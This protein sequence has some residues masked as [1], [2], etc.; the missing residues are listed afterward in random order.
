M[1]TIYK[2]GMGGFLFLVS[3]FLPKNAIY[4]IVLI[5]AYSLL[6]YP[7]WIDVI[8]NIPKFKILDEKFLM[9]IATLG[10]FIIK[11]YPEAVAVI[12]FYQ[13]G[14]YLSDFA[15]D[16][17]KDA[18]GKL[19]D[20]RS[21]VAH[22]KRKNGVFTIPIEEIKVNDIII[23][24]PGEK[25]PLD[26]IILSGNSHLDTSSMTGESILKTVKP[27]DVVISGCLN[28][29]GI[30][31]IKVTT[32]YQE[33]TVSKILR[34]ME[35]SGE[36]KTQQE[37]FITK[38]ANY[39]TPIVV[40]FAMLLTVIPVIFHQPFSI[41][42]YKSLLFLVISCPCAL[43]VSIPI[44]FFSGIGVSSKKGILIKNTLSLEN[45]DQM[46]TVVFDKTGTLTK[47]KFEVSKIIPKERK[48][49]ILRLAAL[50]ESNSNHPIAL[51]IQKAYSKPLTDTIESYQEIVGKGIEVIIRDKK[52]HVGSKTF[53]QE[54]NIVCSK[55][56]T[57]GTIVYVACN[58]EYIGA[59]IIEDTIKET[60]YGLIDHL[61]E[62][63]IQKAILLSGDH[64]RTVKEVGMKLHMDEVYANLLPTDKVELV[65]AEQETNKII[66]VGDGMND[67]PVLM[68][69]DIG[70][71]MGGIGS[72]VAIEASDIVIMNDDPSLL[73]TAIQIAKQ[74]K[75]IV[76]CNIIFALTVKILILFLGLIGISSMWGAV[77]ADVG[78][79]VLTILNA[80][81][82][83]QIKTIS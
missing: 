15:T 22:L 48:E 81:R 16:Q 41:W 35:Q 37:K 67:A 72:D 59:I 83:F 30:L 46:N 7:I 11:E 68:K 75:K 71:S 82:I 80:L 3:F 13:I 76:K 55:L 64:E 78:V 70:V 1:K 23:V 63:G 66:F 9:V 60:A 65:K 54:N 21:D 57:L 61:K 50:A 8:K 52:I 20:L 69:A 73:L 28:K 45:L 38:F 36:T 40:I 6:A 17:T 39:Y 24:K 44:G 34:L 53:M 47:G 12:L 29:E 74:T 51:S 62:V 32:L 49:E 5:L 2:I 77:F 14:E 58:H 26:G 79:T 43:V 18:I 4:P 33:S 10:A 56:D 27:N 19:M 31:E 25:I 42:F